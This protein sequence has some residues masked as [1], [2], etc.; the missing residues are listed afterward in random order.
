MA[1]NYRRSFPKSLRTVFL[2]RDGVINEK[3]PEGKWITRW[4]EFKLLPRVPESIRI[5]ND[6]GAKV[7]V[8]TNQ[9][10]IA[11]NLCTTED[12]CDIHQR[13]S[14]TLEHH[15]A[16]LD[17]FYICPHDRGQCLCRKPLGGMFEQ[18]QKEFA[19]VTADSSLMI[20]DS[21]SDMEFADRLGMYSIFIEGKK[22]TQSPG[23][24]RARLIADARCASLFEAVSL[25][26]KKIE[27]HRSL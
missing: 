10:G 12:I 5:L 17:A 13:L 21:L 18:A 11:L 6:L 25:I 7:L 2:D 1:I 23:I 27:T 4:E 8:V 19:E 16:R 24:D 9:R 15:G 26:L 22:Q 3:A 20:G 14:G